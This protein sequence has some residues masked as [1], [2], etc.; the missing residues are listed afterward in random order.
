[1]TIPVLNMYQLS[2]GLGRHNIVIMNTNPHLYVDYYIG[3]VPIEV[4]YCI[5]L[6][7]FKWSALAMYYRIFRP[8][9]WMRRASCVLAGL[10]FVWTLGSIIGLLLRCHPLAYSWDQEAYPDGYCS[11]EFQEFT[12]VNS[13]PTIFFDV[14][15]LAL[16]LPILFR[17][18]SPRHTRIATLCIFMLGGLVIVFSIVRLVVVLDGSS[19]DDSMCKSFAILLASCAMDEKGISENFSNNQTGTGIS[20][21]LWSVAEPVAGLMSCSIP[22]YAP[23]LRR[24]RR[25]LGYDSNQ[26]PPGDGEDPKPPTQWNFHPTRRVKDDMDSDIMELTRVD[27][28]DTPREDYAAN[29]EKRS[30][31]IR[32][33]ATLGDIHDPSINGHV[34]QKEKRSSWTRVKSTLGP[35]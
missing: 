22:S 5:D 10:I 14:V 35:S 31:W 18:Q 19:Q 24:I 2:N 34:D 32:M 28:N 20:I 4:I 16:P 17:I 13:I 6:A 3:V 8:Y 27:E 7:L 25:R 11:L 26:S 29:R 21:C 9:T 33:K 30:S 12:L 15:I 1:M 23:L